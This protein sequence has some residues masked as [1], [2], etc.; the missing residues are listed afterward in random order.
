[1]QDWVELFF[2]CLDLKRDISLKPGHFP[3]R[4][5]DVEDLPR[6][7]QGLFQ[8]SKLWGVHQRTYPGS[9]PI[10]QIFEIKICHIWDLEQR[11]PVLG[12]PLVEHLRELNNPLDG[13]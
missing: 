3:K 12:N 7:I 9:F 11:G 1:V 10:R 2:P 6:V 5:L 8:L 4:F 13:L